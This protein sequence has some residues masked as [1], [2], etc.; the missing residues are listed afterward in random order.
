MSGVRR[1]EAGNGPE[2]GRLHVEDLA[3][4]FFPIS[5]RCGAT[6][7]RSPPPSPGPWGDRRGI[8]SVIERFE[9]GRTAV[10]SVATRWGGLG[11]RLQGHQSPRRGG[12]R[13]CLP[14]GGP[15]RRRS[16]QGPRSD[17]A[18]GGG[19][20]RRV[21]ALGEA[22][23]ELVAAGGD[24]VTPVADLAEAV[25]VAASVAVPGDTVLLAPGCASF[26]MFDSY[27]HRGDVF[28]TLVEALPTLPRKGRHDRRAIQAGSTR[29]WSGRRLG[30]DRSAP[31]PGTAGGHAGDTGGRAG[32]DRAR[33]GAVV[34]LGHRH[35]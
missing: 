3:L 26:D 5:T 10:G 14:V 7:W 25:T 21:L 30:G 11:R 9:P 18:G 24:L 35:P 19:G 27:A 28:T 16:Q 32:R 20:L 12:R 13:R 34:E 29:T 15:D 8:G 22:T 31:S 23:D 33:G 17:A 1:P 2:G 4:P 6:T